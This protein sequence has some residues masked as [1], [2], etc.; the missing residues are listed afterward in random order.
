MAKVNFE[1]IRKQK[2]KAEQGETD[3]RKK[4]LDKKWFAMI[5]CIDFIF[6]FSYVCKIN[7][8]V[9]FVED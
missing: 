1:Y 9:L 5:G 8:C 6:S 3:K 4:M 7:I 2:E